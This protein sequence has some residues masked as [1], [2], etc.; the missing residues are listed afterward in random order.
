MASKTSRGTRPAAAAPA[1]DT[2]ATSVITIAAELC[3]AQGGKARVADLAKAVVESG[4]TN[5]KGKTPEATVGAHIYVAAKK[6]LLFRKADGERGVV[7][8]T[9]AGL[10]PAV[11]P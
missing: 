8:L 7:E 1:V 3:K 10:T 6:G 2:K 5:L 9:D 11:N 4:R